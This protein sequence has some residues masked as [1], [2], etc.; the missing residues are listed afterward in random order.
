M[1]CVMKI[2]DFFLYAITKGQISL[3]ADQ[4]LCLATGIVQCLFLN[5]KSSGIVQLS[6][7]APGQKP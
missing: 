2:P 3:A 1:S 7:V 4:H 5:S 6:C